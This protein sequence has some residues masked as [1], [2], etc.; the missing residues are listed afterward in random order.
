MRTNKMFWVVV[1]VALSVIPMAAS[2]ACVHGCSDLTLHVNDYVIVLQGGGESPCN[3][4]CG[5]DGVQ[6]TMVLVW[7]CGG[8]EIVTG[9]LCHPN[10]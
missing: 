2:L 10:S 6:Y 1:S 9:H 7:S 3:P 5:S 4:A 8:E